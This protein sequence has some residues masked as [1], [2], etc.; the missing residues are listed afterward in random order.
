[1]IKEAIGWDPTTNILIRGNF[2]AKMAER[3]VK[4]VD[5]RKRS[6][7]KFINKEKMIEKTADIELDVGNTVLL[8]RT[9]RS[10]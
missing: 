6:K 10:L 1:M 9:Q 5:E 8:G 2:K 4:W 7:D 3:A